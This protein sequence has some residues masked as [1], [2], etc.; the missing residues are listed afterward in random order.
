MDMPLS[1]ALPE[2][3]VTYP[4]PAFNP[5]ANTN[6]AVYWGQGANQGRLVDFCQNGAY[7]IINIGFINKFPDANGYP[8]ANF[9]N[10]CGSETYPGTDLPS[11]CPWIGQDIKTCQDVY[12]KKIFLSI[13]G[14]SPTD[15]YLADKDYAESF[16]E[17]LW[18]AFG[19]S[20]ND[21]TPRPFGDAVIDGFDFD[22]ESQ[23]ASAPS[24]APEYQSQYYP[25]LINHFHDVLFPEDTSKS[26][27]ISAAPQCSFPDAHFGLTFFQTTW[28]DF[29]FVQL[30]NTPQCNAFVSYLGG[31]L[32]FFL[33]LDN[34]LDSR[35][36]AMRVYAGLTAG[37]DGAPYDLLAYLPPTLA[38]QWVQTLQYYS[39]FGGVMLWE[40]TVDQENTL[41]GY[42]YSE[43]IKAALTGCGSDYTPDSECSFLQYKPNK[44]QLTISQNGK[45]GAS[46]GQTCEGSTFGN[47]CSQYGN[48]GTTDAFC[49]TVNNCDIRYGLCGADAN[50]APT[51]TTSNSI[52]P[53]PT[54]PAATPVDTPIDT[55]VAN[56][57]VLT[58]AVDTPVF[59]PSAN[60][61]IANT[62]V[63]TPIN[64]PVFTP[65]NTPVDNTPMVNTP[66]VNTPVVNTPVVNT[67]VVNTP[68]VNTPVV[69]TPVVNTPVVNT[70]V[71][72]P[73]GIN[74]PVVDTPI[75]TSSA[76]TPIV[77]TPVFTSSIY[78]P[79]VFSPSGNL[80]IHL[81]TPSASNPVGISGSVVLSNS[82][83]V[84]GPTGLTSS[85]ASGITSAPT[86]FGSLSAPGDVTTTVITTTY[87]DVCPTGITT[88]TTIY[89]TTVCP[90]QAPSDIPSGWTT[91][92]TVCTNC[93][94][95]PTTLTLTR[96]IPTA[97]GPAPTSVSALTTSTV[98]ATQLFTITACP[99]SVTDCPANSKTHISVATSLVPIA[100]TVL[101]APPVAAS[102]SA[103][104]ASV[105]SQTGQ[106]SQ[107][108]SQGSNANGSSDLS[109]S[110]VYAT[111]L[112]TITACPPSVT[113]CPANSK[114]YVSVATS[115]VPVSTT[116]Y[117]VSPVAAVASSSSAATSAAVGGQTG[118]L[119]SQGSQSSSQSGNSGANSNTNGGGFST[120]T[121]YQTQLVTVTQC[122]PS[123]PNCP[124]SAKTTAVFTTAVSSYLTIVPIVATT[125]TSV[126][127]SGSGS[128]S[129]PFTASPASKQIY[130]STVVSG[131]PIQSGVN[132]GS[133][134]GSGS[135]SSSVSSY[136]S[137]PSS[138]AVVPGS[139]MSSSFAVGGSVGS[140]SSNSSNSANA[141]T[142]TAT[143]VTTQLLTL[144]IVPVPAASASASAVL[145]NYR[146]GTVAHLNTPAPYSTP[147]PSAATSS[148]SGS[149]SGSGRTQDASGPMYTGGASASVSRRG[150]AVGGLAAVVAAVMV[151]I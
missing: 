44:P 59:T 139:K 135:R 91:T 50:A 62:P 145:P 31:S 137:S 66:V 114:T 151:L 89:T 95:E 84:S 27:Y 140:G 14:G 65:I 93:G 58:P 94:P 123:V 133:G 34:L 32:D 111:Q 49:A 76:N 45:C 17:F 29:V 35:N 40:A 61:P 107:E 24:D 52:T 22:I 81:S 73:P 130:S 21:G 118:Q 83:Q 128:S 77:G 96:P 100:T 1:L 64:T 54:P 38:W 68:V 132:G 85:P 141:N 48:C 131:V 110:T 42:M 47:C 39:V 121:V 124:A 78:T 12:G 19:P 60:T 147:T 113:N 101:P 11:N 8:G 116:V 88:V 16:A 75:F 125:T 37:L 57:P 10:Q 26:Y 15:Y 70:P 5:Q 79:P 25:D 2:C 51:C 71:F 30:Y 104:T 90:T 9:G 138:V 56:T 63:S 43:Y 41:D 36:P 98:Y 23:M 87:I 55:P 69:N 136:S 28:V 13:G 129:V 144:S 53:T 3:P 102:S 150:V 4:A 112:V 106:G 82:A 18:N 80:S 108:G 33:Y 67:P 109:T 92:V 97:S 142:Q 20:K 74:T 6:V 115:L 72:T 117:P 99:P 119:P 7:D 149:G 86:L 146:N 127:G 134:S 126:G 148:G 143:A 105:G 46:Y 103:T 122:P 120:S